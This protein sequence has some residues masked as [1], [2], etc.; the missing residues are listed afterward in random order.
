MPT[1]T[2]WAPSFPRACPMASSM[3]PTKVDI[4][5]LPK[6]VP[7]VL[8]VSKSQVHSSQASR[9]AGGARVVPS[10]RPRIQRN[11]E[12]PRIQ[13][14]PRRGRRRIDGVRIAENE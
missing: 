5:D 14:R 6:S 7:L 11:L 1:P 10:E 13:T 12:R 8:S 2:G 9:A 4:P 3:L